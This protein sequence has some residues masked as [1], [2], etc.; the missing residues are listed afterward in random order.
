MATI[1]ISELSALTNPDGA[2]EIVVNDSGTS[3]KIT[4]SDL[5][6]KVNS[7]L[8]DSAPATLNT[9]NELAAALGDDANHTTT[10][11]NLIGTRLPMYGGTMTGHLSFNQTADIKFANGQ[12]IHDNGSGG[13]DLISP[14]YSV[15]LKAGTSGAV[16]LHQSGVERLKTTSSG[17][18]VTGNI[19][20][21]DNGRI[22]F[23]VAADLQIYHEGLNSYISDVGTGDLI[24]N[25]N[26]LRLRSNGGADYIRAYSGGD[27]VIYHNGSVKLATTS[28]GIDVTGTIDMY[29]DADITANPN[30]KGLRLRE[31]SGDWL[32]SLGIS[33]VTNTGF[34]IR[35]VAL[36]TYPFV[37]R[38]TTGNVGIGTTTPGYKLDV[39]GSNGSFGVGSTGNDLYFTRNGANYFY[40]TGASS[41][42]SF[43]TNSN[44]GLYQKSN[45]DVGIGTSSP[46]VP[47][48]VAHTSGDGFRV[49]RGGKYLAISGNYASADTHTLLTAPSG[50]AM[51][52]STNGDTER[53][54]ITST[55]NVGIGTTTPSS[56]LSFG[57]DVYGSADSENF[58]RIKIQDQGGVHNDVG[59]GQSASGNMAF[60]VTAG[61]ATIFNQGTDGE[62]MRIHDNGNVG[63][64]TTSPDAK[65]DI[66]SNHSQLRLTDSDDST[67]TLFSSSGNK[68][69]IRQNSTGAD[70]LWLTSAGNLGIGTSAPG[71]KLTVSASGVDGIELSQDTGNGNN[72][73]R[74]LFTNDT[75]SEGIALLAGGGSFSIRTGAIPGNTSG[76]AKLTVTTAGITV[77]GN[78][79][80]S[81][82]V[83]GRDI[84]SDGAKLDGIA[85]GSN[86]YVLPASV[87]HESELSNSTSSTNTSIAA[88]LA[89]VKAAYDKGNHSHPY[90]DSSHT[91]SYLPL[92]GGTITGELNTS[93]LA[94]DGKKVLD[95]PSNSNDR[96]PWNPIATF[97]RG[98]GTPV[99]TD[100]EFRSG[101]NNLNLYNNSGGTAVALTR[102]YTFVAGVRPPTVSSY[103]MKVYWN[104]GA[105][106]PN[107][108]GFYQTITAREN[109]TF[110]QVFQA[111]VPVGCTL[112]INENSQGTRNT[113]YWLTDNVG[114][115]KW[116][117]YVRVSHCGD[118]GT[119]S[120]GGH[121]SL[122]GGTAPL[123]WYIGSC[124]V[125]DMTKAE[126]GQII[127][128]FETAS[129]PSST[130]NGTMWYDIDDDTL[131]Q[132]QDGAW[133]QVS[134]TAAPAVVIYDVNGV[135]V[136]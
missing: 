42:F 109:A 6:T 78:I 70:H 79:A 75:A 30:T 100:E 31:S 3:K 96:G 46:S 9:L 33:G 1:K 83:D 18:A 133:V 26:N 37:I 69:A 32:L 120:S 8:I 128:Y 43:Y 103:V 121:V 49:S 19:S 94:I 56:P 107:H 64:G 130:P 92:T 38:E 34:A 44:L 17:I 127:R 106:S 54:R 102:E 25:A 40:G 80:V 93:T 113:S 59:I 116:E 58:Y 117:W 123:T 67:Y 84:A 52:F 22:A 39:K 53:M 122:S 87:I 119:F 88:N 112:N 114:T 55:G 72:S 27:V 21:I 23:G 63:I 104:G 68:L 131:Y 51:A 95:L 7:I 126:A 57:K 108:G 15:K 24:I 13:L 12:I 62:R 60:N 111:K 47:L 105:A 129:A 77:A 98:S 85:S 4:I 11:T 82:T 35:D 101:T 29:Q 16:E 115:G 10:M 28:G 81:G 135:I 41:S 2:E 76:T 45:G 74:L 66:E 36:G 65:L 14:T 90:A 89:G 99:Y 20:L 86:N 91:H 136:N 97:I 73:G 118:S 71:T 61:Q 132:R 48:E 110:A 5:T 134:T 124:N 125:Y 50:M